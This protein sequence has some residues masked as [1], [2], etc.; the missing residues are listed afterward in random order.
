MEFMVCWFW[1]IFCWIHKRRQLQQSKN[2]F[3]K[4]ANNIVLEYMYYAY[5]K[6]LKKENSYQNGKTRVLKKILLDPDILRRYTENLG[7]RWLCGFFVLLEF[8]LLWGLEIFS[9]RFSVKTKTKKE[10][11]LFLWWPI[12]EFILKCFLYWVKSIENYVTGVIETFLIILVWGLIVI[13]YI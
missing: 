13:L 4:N 12:L 11:K 10:I 8:G 9:I 7:R 5:K 2:T 6:G 3:P 1:S